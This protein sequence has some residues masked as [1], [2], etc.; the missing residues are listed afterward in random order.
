MRIEAALGDRRGRVVTVLTSDSVMSAAR[1]LRS[2]NVGALIVKDICATEGD[3]V[4]GVLSERDV[5]QAIVDHGAAAFTMPVSDLMTRAVIFCQSDDSIDDAL[6]KMN[7]HHIRH[8]PVLQDGALIGVVSIR[9][10]LAMKA[11]EGTAR[12]SAPASS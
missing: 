11:A 4:L 6:A 2:D 3:A 9:D 7:R 10:V 1:R 12:E 8:L 5:V